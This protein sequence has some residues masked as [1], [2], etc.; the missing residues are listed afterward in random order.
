MGNIPKRHTK[1]ISA[2]ILLAML[3]ASPTMGEMPSQERV[4]TLSAKDAVMLAFKNNRSL[5]AI[6]MDVAAA[7]YGIDD[8]KS[9]FYPRLDVNTG[10]QYN[11]SVLEIYPG[12]IPRSVKK[13]PGI[14]IGYVNS[15]RIGITAREVVYDGGA[16]YSSLRQA[17]INLKIQEETLRAVK[18]DTVFE[19]KRLYYGLLLAK[20]TERI[21][22]E[23]LSQKEEHYKEAD[24]KFSSG[25]VSR[26]ELLQAKVHVSKTRPDVVRAA[27]EAESIQADLKRLLGLKM[28]D[29]IIL[30]D[31]LEAIGEVGTDEKSALERAYGLRPEIKLKQLG[32]DLNKW[33]I[34]MAR[35]SGLPTVAVS[36]GQDYISNDVSDM[37]DYTHSDWNAGIAV[38]I[39]VFNG[40]ST[41]ARVK[42]ARSR[43]SRAIIEKEDILEATAVD[44]KKACLDIAEAEAII[45][46]QKD[47][48]GEAKEALAI[49][50]VSYS[51]G[52]GT[53]LDVHDA[54]V[55]LSQI[56]KNLS[57]GIYDRIIAEAYLD[58][59]MGI[60]AKEE[61]N[62]EQNKDNSGG[63]GMSSGGAVSREKK[64]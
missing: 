36:W 13:D 52:T 62:G 14:F 21:A 27:N 55:S 22:R 31:K 56:E 33:S 41:R 18:A 63:R 53:N 9:V 43:Y 44:V 57:D 28:T 17:Q 8:A 51:A 48:V 23:L 58:K 35:S 49:A 64:P 29:R 26:F 30:T 20:E 47:A 40:F 45:A 1:I 2:A 24:N 6:E 15:N 50:N 25:T 59:V 46:S 42:E 12:A 37:F 54:E 34:E 3:A 16:N 39:P 32:V 4:I 38:S 60:F 10:Y 11:A 7:R 19:T 5:Q 61:I